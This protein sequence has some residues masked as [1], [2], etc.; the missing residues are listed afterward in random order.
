MTNTTKKYG[1]LFSFRILSYLWQFKMFYSI[2]IQTLKSVADF[3][4]MHG[5]GKNSLIYA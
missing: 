4:T 1:K 2:P 5:V 3:I